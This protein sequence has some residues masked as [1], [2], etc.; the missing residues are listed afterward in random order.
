MTA[1]SENTN[2]SYK[3]GKLENIYFAH[4]KKRT[5]G[6][7]YNFYTEIFANEICFQSSRQSEGLIKKRK[8][9]K[10]DESCRIM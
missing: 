5:G 7:S 6:R 8:G 9:E 4:R 3:N 10:K 1:E 2:H